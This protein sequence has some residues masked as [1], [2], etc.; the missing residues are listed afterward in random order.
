MFYISI[1]FFG[2]FF[3][4]ILSIH[5]VSNAHIKCTEKSFKY[6]NFKFKDEYLPKIKKK[7]MN[8]ILNLS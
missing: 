6:L 5:K 7:M 3:I 2:T 8:L 1:F 4:S